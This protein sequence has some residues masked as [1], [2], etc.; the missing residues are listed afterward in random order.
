[1]PVKLPTSG[2]SSGSFKELMNFPLSIQTTQP[3]PLATGH[4]WVESD[5]NSSITSVK[6]LEAMNVGVEN[7]T[8]MIVVGELTNNTFITTHKKI[9]TNGGSKTVHIENSTH[10]NDWL[11]NN[12][13]GDLTHQFYINPPIC[14]YSKIAN[15][16]DV[17]TSYMWD[18]TT[19]KQISQKGNYLITSP[20]FRTMEIYNKVGDNYTLTNTMTFDKDVNVTLKASIDGAYLIRYGNNYSSNYAH[21]VFKRTGDIFTNYYEV[22]YYFKDP[23]STYNTY[24]VENMRI[25]SDFSTI[26]TIGQYWNSGNDYRYAVL[27]YKNNGSTFEQKHFYYLGSSDNTYDCAINMNNDGSVIIASYVK[28]SSG[29][30]TE[31]H[32]LIES[33]DT[34]LKGYLPLPNNKDTSTTYSL[35]SSVVFVDNYMYLTTTVSSGS[36]SQ[37]LIYEIDHLNAKFTY[38]N[39]RS[40]N[41][42]PTI[43]AKILLNGHLAI[44]MDSQDGSKWKAYDYK[45]GTHYTVSYSTTEFPL[46]YFISNMAVN[47]TQDR[48]AITYG[49]SGGTSHRLTILIPTIDKTNKIVTLTKDRDIFTQRTTWAGPLTFLPSA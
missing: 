21:I 22:P 36:S 43:S 31:T 2:G 6:I 27:I 45:D 17:E 24:Y 11:I 46:S 33:G 8:L 10:G 20:N 13:T 37:M 26:A 44:G 15:V 16:V 3:T 32:Y 18:G 35:A 12:Y 19:W 5:K 39:S 38:L 4:I 9:L 29:T 40:S 25:S 49:T 1:M 34:Y 30:S 41:S 7:G 14:I 28:Y 47:L 23:N 48:I 42:M